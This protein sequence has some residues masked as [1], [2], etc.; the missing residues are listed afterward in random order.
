MK[1][2]LPIV[3]ATLLLAGQVQAGGPVVVV[4]DEG[5]TV[6]E[7]PVS[8]AGKLPLLLIPV[9]LCIILCGGDDQPAE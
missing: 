3:A 1:P 9:F 7:A 6:A 4:E 5:E 2:I 8:S